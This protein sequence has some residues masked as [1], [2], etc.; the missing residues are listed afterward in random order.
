ME[1]PYH[2]AHWRLWFQQLQEANEDAAARI[3]QRVEEAWRQFGD[4]FDLGPYGT[5][6]QEAGLIA[7]EETLWAAWFSEVQEVIQHMPAGPLEKQLGS[8]RFGEHTA[9]LDH[10]LHILSG[11]YNSDREAVW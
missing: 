3:Q 1:Q 10:A 8:G 2:L 4:A 9:D 5:E 11:V 6:M 7:D